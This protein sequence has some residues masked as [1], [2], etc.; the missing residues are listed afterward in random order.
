[1]T[2]GDGVAQ[3]APDD[4]AEN[5]CPGQREHRARTGERDQSVECSRRPVCRQL[6]RP[7]RIRVP[8]RCRRAL[9][10][11]AGSPSQPPMIQTSSFPSRQDGSNARH[12][13]F[14]PA[15]VPIRG[16]AERLPFIARDGRSAVGDVEAGKPWRRVQGQQSRDHRLGHIT[17]GGRQTGAERDC[18]FHVRRQRPSRRDEPKT[19]TGMS[20]PSVPS[21]R[22][23]HGNGDRT[24]K[25]G[26]TFGCK[27]F[28]QEAKPCRRTPDRSAEAR[29]ASLLRPAKSDTN[30]PRCSGR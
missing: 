26:T 27:P 11:A 22:R 30:R 12:A 9:A 29:R 10:L 17:S 20:A 19:V 4:L 15:K 1:M 25:M 5:A 6:R 21:L 7:C 14:V 16:E 2:A 28:P 13:N 3:G 18:C 24:F 8:H 23:E